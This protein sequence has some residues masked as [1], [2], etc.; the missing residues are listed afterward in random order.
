MGDTKGHERRE[1]SI[2]SFLIDDL[3]QHV[4]GLNPDDLVFTGLRGNP[5]R[6]QIFQRATLDQ[7]CEQAGIPRVTPHELRHTAATPLP[8]WPSPQVL[9]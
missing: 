2:P 4:A 3:A 8:A 7:A 6:S 1:I 5:L 9:T